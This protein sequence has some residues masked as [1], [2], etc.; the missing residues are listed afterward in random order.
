M[1]LTYLA[2]V[3]FDAFNEKPLTY[4][5]TNTGYLFYSVGSNGVDDGGKLVT[6]VPRGDDVGV[7]MPWK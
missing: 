4:R 1:T 3:P 7:R 2:K 5:K 6:D